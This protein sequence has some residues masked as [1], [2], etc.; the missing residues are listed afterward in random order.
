MSVSVT[1]PTH[2]LTS[3]REGHR[4]PPAGV[5]PASSPTPPSRPSASPL[6][7]AGPSGVVGAAAA[8]G[9][10]GDA[11]GVASG[12][13]LEPH[14]HD[15]HPPPL[16]VW[17]PLSECGLGG[18]GEGGGDGGDGRS[19]GA[20]AGGGASANAR[21]RRAAATDPTAAATLAIKDVSSATCRVLMLQST[22]S[23]SRCASGPRKVSPSG[24]LVSPP[25]TGLS[26]PPL[27]P[28][29]PPPLL[30]PPSVAPPRGGAVG[31]TPIA[32]LMQSRM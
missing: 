8:G 14:N 23:T 27:P 19:G 20:A 5:S 18:G 2:A 31:G 16:P 32:A 29:P 28:L 24:M 10:C 9:V 11:A 26:S 17:L 7:P 6:L 12:T 21:R 15:V 3:M 1:P 4:K 25:S 22:Q 13:G 30:P